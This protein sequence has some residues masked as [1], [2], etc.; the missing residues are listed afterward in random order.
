ML[1]HKQLPPQAGGG[2]G[3]E[4]GFFHFSTLENFSG[5]CIY[6]FFLCFFCV[7]C[8]PCL[9]RKERTAKNKEMVL[10]R[11]MPEASPSPPLPL[12]LSLSATSPL[13]PKTSLL[14]PATALGSFA[15]AADLMGTRGFLFMKVGEKGKGRVWLLSLTLGEN[16]PYLMSP[17]I[18]R[19]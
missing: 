8:P 11:W 5:F 2:G 15:D 14:K 19:I 3:R 16:R 1:G 13:T 4:R 12:L 7:V 9:K 17:I 10:G 6:L 18:S